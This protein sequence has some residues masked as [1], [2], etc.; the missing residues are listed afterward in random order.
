MIVVTRVCVLRTHISWPAASTLVGRRGVETGIHGSQQLGDPVLSKVEGEDRQTPTAFL[1]AH[2]CTHR[3]TQAHAWLV[4]LK[5]IFHAYW[6]F[7]SI[8]ELLSVELY[9][10]W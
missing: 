9:Y 3:H 1:T 8:L 6:P 10:V 7:V 5:N 4:N 2:S